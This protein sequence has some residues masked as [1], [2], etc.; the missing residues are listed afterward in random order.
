MP[1]GQD[2]ER[3]FPSGWICDS[4]LIPDEYQVVEGGGG[5]EEEWSPENSGGE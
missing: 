5:Q 4:H 3:V 2:I 1:S